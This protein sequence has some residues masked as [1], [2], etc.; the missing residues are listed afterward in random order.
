MVAVVARAEPLTV[1]TETLGAWTYL[2]PLN[3]YSGGDTNYYRDVSTPTVLSFR[4]HGERV[5][6]ILPGSVTVAEFKDGSFEDL[7]LPEEWSPY[8][9]AVS[10]AGKLFCLVA[11]AERFLSGPGE[12]K[13]RW[14]IGL[15]AHGWD[16]PIFIPWQGCDRIEFD[17][18]DRLWAL[19]TAPQTGFFAGG[20]WTAYTY[21]DDRHLE[22]LPLRISEPR[23]GQVTVFACPT[24]RGS[25][26]EVSRLK[27][28]LSYED[29]E[30][31][32]QPQA[33]TTALAST[34]TRRY[35]EPLGQPGFDNAHGYVLH[36]EALNA[37]YRGTLTALPG[38]K[39][40]FVSLGNQ[41]F[42]WA[43]TAALAGG[44]A[45]KTDEWESLDDITIPPTLD[46]A[47]NL[48]VGCNKQLRKISL[49]GEVIAQGELQ[50]SGNLR[51]IDFDPLG[52]PWMMAWHG[53][54]GGRVTLCDHDALRDYPDFAMALRAQRDALPA[55][56][57]FPFACKTSAGILAFGGGYFEEFTVID[58]TGIHRFTDRQIAPHYVAPKAGH[59]YN[60][61]RGGEP[62]VDAAGNI[63]T[64]VN[65]TSYR[66][67]P[68]RR[69]WSP[70]PD[71]QGPP[72]SP[73]LSAPPSDSAG[74]FGARLGLRDGSEIVF[75]GFHFFL[76]TAKRERQ[77]D[78]GLN[79]LAS[80]PFWSSWYRSPGL[81]TPVMDPAG[82]LWI[83]PLGPY[84]DGHRWLRLR[85]AVDGR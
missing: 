83:S 76:R 63:Y 81:T 55:G 67:H 51:T 33:D 52:R 84:A 20:K 32:R 26:S 14:A 34:E 66:Y 77:L 82:H 35:A 15:G 12:W 56:Q 54:G 40:Y 31:R 19:G 69:D 7:H 21:S 45:L 25:A 24:W 37:R 3:V 59:G 71:N 73:L 72:S 48:W 43:E 41:G 53:S 29:G 85:A 47:G 61:F 57:I 78:T 16:P 2:Y 62:V 28:A 70:V 17:S 79:P 23:P 9:L 60:P 27:G 22:F 50:V 44:P 58:S 75:K 6:V 36:G 30:F 39:H 68:E 64:R 74:P 65:G 80:Y 11:H 10:H 1:K 49:G 4:A 13:K 42:A 5:A 38:G 8:S 46:S 18:A